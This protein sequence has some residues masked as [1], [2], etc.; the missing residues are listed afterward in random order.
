M[1]E[2]TREMIERCKRFAARVIRMVD[3]LPKSR[4]ADV[5]GRQIIASA[6]SVGANYRAAQRGRSR[7]EFLSKLGIVEEEADETIYWLE[8]IAETNLMKPQRLTELQ[9]EADEILSIVVASIRSAR[10]SKS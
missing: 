9:H 5:L 6:S 1:H 4:S 7:A 10:R 8:L 2:K 3:Q